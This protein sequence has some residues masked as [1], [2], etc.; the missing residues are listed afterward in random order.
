[1]TRQLIDT[2]LRSPSARRSPT[3][4]VSN[5]RLVRIRIRVHCGAHDLKSDSDV[6]FCRRTKTCPK[7]RRLPQ[8]LCFASPLDSESTMSRPNSDSSTRPTRRSP[9]R[10]R[11]GRGRRLLVPLQLQPGRPLMT[12][13]IANCHLSPLMMR[14]THHHLRLRRPHY[15]CKR[16]GRL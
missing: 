12:S 7:N 8:P 15:E 14:R 13:Q 9:R 16:Q 6:F 3:S 2:Y 11:P 4:P 10:W 1:M 5:V